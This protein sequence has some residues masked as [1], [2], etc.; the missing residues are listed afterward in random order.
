VVRGAVPLVRYGISTTLVTLRS[1]GH[2][3]EVLLNINDTMGS[4]VGSL[5]APRCKI[6]GT[7][8]KVLETVNGRDRD[9]KARGYRL[10]LL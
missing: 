4:C 3:K 6:P 1:V 10:Q 8:S 9:K 7:N 5:L 2:E